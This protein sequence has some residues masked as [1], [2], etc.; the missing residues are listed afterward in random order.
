M[1][2][3]IELI[4]MLKGRENY[5]DAWLNT[6]GV[7]SRAKVIEG[8]Q[9]VDL[10]G[11]ETLTDI[12]NVGAKTCELMLAADADI[13]LLH[14]EEL[15]EWADACEVRIESIEKWAERQAFLGFPEGFEGVLEAK[16]QGVLEIS[17]PEDDFFGLVAQAV[18]AIPGIHLEVLQELEGQIQSVRPCYAEVRDHLGKLD[19]LLK[20][21]KLVEWAE[22][23]ETGREELHAR[24][25]EELLA[26]INEALAEEIANVRGRYEARVAQINQERE[27]VLAREEEAA[28]AREEEALHA[29]QVQ[30]D[31]AREEKRR[32]ERSGKRQRW[33]QDP[34][35]GGVLQ[36]MRDLAPLSVQQ[37]ARRI[38]ADGKFPEGWK[39]EDVLNKLQTCKHPDGT[40]SRRFDRFIAERYGFDPES[41]EVA[42]RSQSVVREDR[43]RP[44]HYQMDLSDL[45]QKFS[46]PQ[47]GLGRLA[48]EM[49]L[50]AAMVC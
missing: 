8:I 36:L 42:R 41:I 2:H 24:I 38:N 5:L 30:A 20:S 16:F 26:T 50:W 39:W 10:E 1:V 47:T 6:I 9:S 23:W 34:E 17:P 11:V 12:P 22:L 44:L 45:R 37:V 31:Q 7:R 43:Q 4:K 13:H 21:G 32:R 29:A 48:E 27:A 46:P 28:R 35:F 19:D 33:V 49:S 14:A 3:H 18:E 15:V 40:W 25:P